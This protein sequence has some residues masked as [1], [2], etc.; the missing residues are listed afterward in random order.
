[1]QLCRLAQPLLSPAFNSERLSSDQ[2]TEREFFVGVEITQI[3]TSLFLE[4]FSQ[5]SRCYPGDARVL[6][7][8]LYRRWSVRNPI[9]STADQSSERQP[10]SAADLGAYGTI[11]ISY[12]SD[13][14]G[15]ARKLFAD[16]QE[17][18]S[19]RGLQRQSRR[20]CRKPGAI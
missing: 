3:A 4:R 17:I 16:V 18:G 5:D 12:S 2:R 8:E 11:F 13:D 15:A 10:D 9:T 7:S 1:L 20:L 19:G 14:I 6:A